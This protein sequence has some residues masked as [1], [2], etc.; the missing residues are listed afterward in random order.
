MKRNKRFSS[1]SQYKNR[2]IKKNNVNVI[3]V[4]H[5]YTKITLLPFPIHIFYQIINDLAKKT[6]TMLIV[7]KNKLKHF[8]VCICNFNFAP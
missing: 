1:Q 3:F 8:E 6:E 2:N 4:F 7:Y 5:F